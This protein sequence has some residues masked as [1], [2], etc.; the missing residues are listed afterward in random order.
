MKRGLACLMALVLLF[1]SVPTSVLAEVITSQTTHEEAGQEVSQKKASD[2]LEA[3]AVDTVNA[4][5]V[6]TLEVE[7]SYPQPR[8]ALTDR[9]AVS[10]TN[11]AG[12]IVTISLKDVASDK[13]TASL[14]SQSI[15]YKNL[16]FDKN[17]IGD[18]SMAG[19][20]LYNPSAQDAQVYYTTVNFYDLP[21]DTY[22]LTLSDTGLLPVTTTAAINTT[23]KR[24]E[25][26]AKALLTGDVDGNGAIDDVDYDAVLAKLSTTE[27]AYDLN[28]DGTVDIIDLV[29]LQEGLGKTIDTTAIQVSETSPVVNPEGVKLESSAENP[30]SVKDGAISQLFGAS[31]TAT[32][33]VGFQ[34]QDGQSISTNTP[35]EIP[36]VMAETIQASQIRLEPSAL[37]IDHAAKKGEVIV[38]N[39]AGN[40]EIYYFGTEESTAVLFLTDE[41]SENTI[42]IDLKGQTA[43]KKITIRVTETTK[44]SSNLVEISKVE[45]LNNTKD[46]IVE[47]VSSIP[48]NVRATPGNESLSITW[49]TQ[50]NVTGYE[51]KM[52]FDNPK[53][54]KNETTITPVDGNALTI[55]DL[56]NY[57][58]Y[59]ISVQS[60][61]RSDTG[62][63][64]SGYS[65]PIVATPLPTSVPEAPE[66]ITLSGGYRQ[67]TVNW[68]KQKNSTGYNVYYREKGK[69]EYSKIG[70]LT[71]TST[72]IT[73]LKDQTEYEIYLRG[74]NAIGEGAASPV[75]RCETKSIDPPITSNYKLINRAN[76]VDEP[77]A[78]ITDITYPYLKE[79][80]YENGFDQYD[81]TD[82]DYTSY[83][84][85]G[86]WNAGG[87]AGTLQGPM[88]WTISF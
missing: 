12:E 76:G 43:I 29:Y 72:V 47:Q 23:S 60:V 56:T 71:A 84:N 4:K 44:A 48:T 25:V 55:G 32:E 78:H 17:A 82:N 86:G 19:S 42:V 81:I 5:A 62:N 41:P 30:V 14:G 67:I 83:W 16:L 63:W 46:K 1:V 77:T 58:D 68:E 57:V 18:G 37:G 36:L 53:T 21:V 9:A 74:Y 64:E 75:Y 28:G 40:D 45:F 20:V 59:T 31:T 38:T 69:T 52:S 34:R 51:V 22:T 65:A 11:T 35:L 39:E 61:N 2:L 7:I 33:V 50:A 49:D 15:Q 73:D 79:G 10:L 24:V 26:N 87:W 13:K 27:A 6:G 8:K 88:K 80:D 3:E 66:A 70:G 54:G 85:Y